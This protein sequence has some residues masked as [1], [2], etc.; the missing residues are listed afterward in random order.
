MSA[1][2]WL[3]LQNIV[4]LQYIRYRYVWCRGPQFVISPMHECR[5]IRLVIVA[6]QFHKDGEKRFEYSFIAEA[7]KL[8]PEVKCQG[9]QRAM[10]AFRQALP[11]E[12]I[13]EHSFQFTFQNRAR[14]TQ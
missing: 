6:V 7:G 14:V 12:H 9:I 3:K 13:F 2:Y 5:E 1:S 11:L 4:L 10:T 8:T